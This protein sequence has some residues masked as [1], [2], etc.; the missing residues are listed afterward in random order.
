MPLASA[1]APEFSK[2]RSIEAIALPVARYVTKASG[3][4]KSGE[5]VRSRLRRRALPANRPLRLIGRDTD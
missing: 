5:M 1:V 3:R 4:D 2:S